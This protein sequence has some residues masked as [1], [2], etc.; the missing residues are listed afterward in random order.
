MSCNIR[1]VR[2]LIGDTDSAAYILS[3]QDIRT[4]STV[5]GSGNLA[6][7]I[8][9]AESIAAQYAGVTN[10]SVDD[11]TAWGGDLA[12]KY[13]AVA[14]RLRAQLG[15]RVAM[16]YSG[17]LTVADHETRREDDSLVPASFTRDLH[18]VTGSANSP[19]NDEDPL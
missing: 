4:L 14:R 9:A 11:V 1:L 17:G 5:S 16:P 18:E 2:L 10:G 12:A 15:R 19:Y 7:A 3:D 13:T 8:L 6:T